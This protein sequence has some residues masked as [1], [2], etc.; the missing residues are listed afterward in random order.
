MATTRSKIVAE[1]IG[2]A[3]TI[4]TAKLTNNAVT[5]AKLA[6]SLDLSSSTVSLPLGVGGTDWS[7]SVK[8]ADFPADSNK[9]YYLNTSGGAI[10]VTL[11]TSGLQI[12]NIVSLVNVTP[13][14]TSN[15][16]IIT[17]NGNEINGAA[18]D[19]E[20]STVRSGV[21]LT[22]SGDVSGG[23]FGW[24][25]TE[26]ANDYNAEILL[27]TN[28]IITSFA[29]SAGQEYFQADGNIITITGRNFKS[30]AVVKFRDV[31][32]GTG[33]YNYTGVITN[34][35]GNGS[36][37]Y[38][39][40]DFSDTTIKVK[41]PTNMTPDSGNTQ[42][43]RD[44]FDIQVTNAGDSK[45]AEKLNLLEYLPAPTF[46]GASTTLGHIYRGEAV[47]T[48]NLSGTSVTITASSLDSDDVVAIATTPTTGSLPPGMTVSVS[49]SSGGVDTATLGGTITSLSTASGKENITFKLTATATSGAESL[50]QESSTYTVELRSTKVTSATA[51]TPSTFVG[52]SGSSF[53]INGIGFNG[54]T[55]PVKSAGSGG[56]KFVKLTSSSG[57]GNSFTQNAGNINIV[58]D[59]QMIVTT[60]A[61]ITA[62]QA[63]AGL[64]V[65]VELTNG[66][67]FKLS[68]EDTFSLITAPAGIT[69]GTPTTLTTIPPARGS[70][71]VTIPAGTDNSGVAPTL[72]AGTITPSGSNLTYNAGTRVVSGTIP[73]NFEV[74]GG[75]LTVPI[76][77]TDNVGNTLLQNYT[78][79]I[80][81]QGFSY[82]LGISHS[83]L[84]NGS[85]YLG[86]TYSGSA[87][88]LS[89]YTYSLW[90]KLSSITVQNTFL[91]FKTTGSVGN[92][93]GSIHIDSSNL[94]TVYYQNTGTY[95]STQL[96]R[97]TSAW[98]HFVFSTNSNVYVNGQS[99]SSSVSMPPIVLSHHTSSVEGNANA[100]LKIGDWWPRTS[101][102]NYPM[103]GYMANIDFIDGQ[104]LSADYFGK[105]QDGVWVAKAFNGDDNAGNSATNNYGANGFKLTFADSSDLGK[106][107]AP[108]TGAHSAANNWTNN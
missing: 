97:D 77:F 102:A 42:D 1:L 84:F 38:P 73:A 20:I 72:S 63:G 76:T 6:T 81:A 26:T 59:T 86:K 18:F 22:Y 65:V 103:N 39:D 34:A 66:D 71:S 70:Y 32:A 68:E 62:G 67:I 16:I 11:P 47:D 94:L 31:A 9:G 23:G 21:Q 14:A 58:S 19:L 85:S 29:N 69:A 40:S 35:A 87:P 49:G 44:P 60:S 75:T 5:V 79:T 64:D 8:T 28:P 10:T 74:G 92:E 80:E 89:T 12:G 15:K 51:A 50:T 55:Y 45:S 7:T 100:S 27:V 90:V 82:P 61:D 41:I 105:T 2:T 93:S 101:S 3:G 106:D 36:P 4:D 57:D 96:F 46:G 104:A 108:L 56:V 98:Y 95:Q 30:D 91:S 25:A 99:I 107:T 78:A 53:T 43:G 13:L 37:T 48:T 17:P 88:T 52:A 54:S 33:A 24:I 83:A